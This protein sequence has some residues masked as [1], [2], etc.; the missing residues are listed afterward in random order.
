MEHYL[1]STNKIE[2]FSLLK[3]YIKKQNAQVAN[4][5]FIKVIFHKLFGKYLCMKSTF[6]WI[7]LVNDQKRVEKV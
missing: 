3:S 7:L 1:E 5:L 4:Y 2:C 6:I